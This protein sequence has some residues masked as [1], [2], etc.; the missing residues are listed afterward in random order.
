[1]P[2]IPQNMNRE[3]L[4]ELYYALKVKFKSE[5]IEKAELDIDRW[6]RSVER[7]NSK[8]GQ[9]GRQYEALG[10]AI[11]EVKKAIDSAIEGVNKFGQMYNATNISTAN[12]KKLL[13]DTNTQIIQVSAAY[14]RYGMKLNDFTR[15][16]ETMRSKYKLTYDESLKLTQSIARGFDYHAPQEFIKTLDTMMRGFNNNLEA[17][18]SFREGIEKLTEDS[19]RT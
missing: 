12:A 6:G 16:I 19:K 9:M 15:Q 13:I 14:S 3:E 2:D 18:N 10:D 5:G 11:G 1:M 17:V 7:A 4:R 8:I